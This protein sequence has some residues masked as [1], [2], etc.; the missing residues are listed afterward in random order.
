[1]IIK[2]YIS[3]LIPKST[4]LTLKKPIKGFTRRAS[5]APYKYCSLNNSTDNKNVKRK[6]PKK[7]R[8][9]IC[10]KRW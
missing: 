3:R 5:C 7:K 10:A 8:E 1:M 6:R 4:C 9:K 2:I